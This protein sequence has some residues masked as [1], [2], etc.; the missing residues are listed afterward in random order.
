MEAQFEKAKMIADNEGTW[1]C[2]NLPR[3]QVLNFLNTMEQKMYTLVIRKFRKKRSLDANAMAWKLLGD[4][5]A[6]VGIPPEEV[7][8]E[9]IR[10]VGGNYEIFPVRDEIAERF[11]DIWAKDHIGW[12]VDYLG[13]SKI[14]GYANFRCFYGSSMYDTKQMSRLLDLIIDECNQLGIETLDERE[15]TLLKEEWK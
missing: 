11:P 5:S 7:Y 13:P 12:F 15:L 1:L 10:D 4:I 6:V 3:Q 9:L 2:L 8:R 14:Q